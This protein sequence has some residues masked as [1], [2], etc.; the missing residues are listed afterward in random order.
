VVGQIAKIRGC[1]VVGIAGGAEKCR[2]VVDEL[3][4]DACVDYRSATF[5]TSLAQACPGGIDVYFE[6]VGGAVRDTA[7]GLMNDFGRIAVCGLI[8]EYSAGSELAG[9]GWFRLLTKRLTVQGFLLRDHQERHVAIV[10][11]IGR[12]YREGRIKV[13]EQIAEGLEQTPAAFIAML[14]GGNFGKTLVRLKG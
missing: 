7:W 2:Y 5:K 3:G 1:R 14:Q 11:D 8:S 13:R 12:W 6:N 10:E 4:L 9:P